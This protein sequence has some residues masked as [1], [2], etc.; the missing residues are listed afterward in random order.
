MYKLY[1]EHGVVRFIM[2]GRLRWVGHVMRVEGSDRARKVLCATPGGTGD[3]RN[4]PK[5]RWCDELEDVTRVG[6]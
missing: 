4:R 6:D 3:R 1:D 5:L 2:L